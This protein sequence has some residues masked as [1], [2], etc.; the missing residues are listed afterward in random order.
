MHRTAKAATILLGA[1]AFAAPVAAASPSPTRGA[2]PSA[3]NHGQAVVAV[4]QA[5][6]YAS[7]RAKGAAVSAEARKQG[8]ARRA[9]AQAR[10]GA[11][12][13]ASPSASNAANRGTESEPGRL[14]AGS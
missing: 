6:D 1:L 5:A 4:A 8:E 3:N 14:K 13:S 9:Q 12:A 7:G 11:R 10:A 2:D